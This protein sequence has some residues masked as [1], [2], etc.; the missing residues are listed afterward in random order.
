MRV[1]R[2]RCERSLGLR[3][4]GGSRL[5]RPR[6]VAYSMLPCSRILLLVLCCCCRSA[7]ADA[8]WS[9]PLFLFF[10]TSNQDTALLPRAPS[11]HGVSGDYVQLY[12]EPVVFAHSLSGKA[13]HPLVSLR[14]YWSEE[15]KDIQTTEWSCEELNAHGGNY[16]LLSTIGL[17]AVSLTAGNSAAAF[18]PLRLSFDYNRFDAATAPLNGADLDVAIPGTTSFDSGRG[19]R[20]LGFV[21]KAACS[22]C[23]ISMSEAF[24]SAGGADC[25][26]AC[27]AST[28]CATTT[29]DLTVSGS[30]AAVAFNA[31]MVKAGK[32][33]QTF[34]HAK[35]ESGRQLHMSL[36]YFCC[37]SAVDLQ[38]IKGVLEDVDWPPLNVS[39]ERPV[40]RI[41]GDRGEAP[42][43]EAIDHQSIIVLLDEP[44]QRQMEGLVAD[45]EERV[46]AVGLDVHVPRALQ[47]PFHSTLGVVSGGAFPAEAALAAVDQAVPSGRW[48]SSGP[49]TLGA[50]SI[51]F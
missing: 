9:I 14:A 1:L 30:P 37:Y 28:S 43:R 10:S 8:G 46:R 31:A 3:G 6:R 21:K 27:D 48:T 18:V 15:R 19:A 51:N 20:T 5:S 26:F 44:S 29:Y 47:E 17:V 39:F 2:G 23:N 32:I 12:D 34:G 22:V 40:W 4:G 41:D 13:S 50:P 42:T 11:T 16:T 36:N 49:I 33:L 24:P 45:L 38:T 35:V 7:A 25:A